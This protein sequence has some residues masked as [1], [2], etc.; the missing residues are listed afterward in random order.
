MTYETQAIERHETLT[1]PRRVIQKPG[2]REWTPAKDRHF[3]LEF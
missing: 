2:D 3:S 1:G